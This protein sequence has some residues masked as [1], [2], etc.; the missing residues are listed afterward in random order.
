[1][2]DKAKLYIVF[3]GNDWHYVYEHS[4][5]AHEPGFA[6]PFTK[7][8]KFMINNLEIGQVYHKSGSDIAVVRVVS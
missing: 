2:S 1:M 5:Y 4:V 7:E 6:K 3:D 8:D